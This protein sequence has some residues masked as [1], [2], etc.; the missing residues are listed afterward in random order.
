MRFIIV[1]SASMVEGIILLFY[2]VVGL[3]TFVVMAM[4][5]IRVIRDVRVIT[6]IRVIIL[7]S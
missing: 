4:R 1:I 2:G 5:V 7:L 3:F 6:V